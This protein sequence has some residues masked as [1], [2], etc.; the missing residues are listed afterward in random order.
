ME[1]DILMAT[2]RERQQGRSRARE[3]NLIRAGQERELCRRRSATGTDDLEHD[4]QREWDLIE[5]SW[6]EQEAANDPS[7]RF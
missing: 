1:G 5:G 2:V 6:A 3:T 7:Y 4:A